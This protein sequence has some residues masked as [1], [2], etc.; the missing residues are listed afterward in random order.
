M[1]GPGGIDERRRPPLRL[2]PTREL[3]PEQ[4]PQSPPPLPP[5][6][7]VVEAERVRAD[8]ATQ[9]DARV[10][11]LGAENETRA[12]LGGSGVEPNGPRAV[13]G[14]SRAD[15]PPADLEARVD[16]LEAEGRRGAFA[17]SPEAAADYARRFREVSPHLDDDTR[18]HLQRPMDEF[19]ASAARTQDP[20][21]TAVARELAPALGS[22][23]VEAFSHALLSGPD[24]RAREASVAVL[25]RAARD[26]ADPL[27][28]RQAGNALLN[29]GPTLDAALR[30]EHPSVSRDRLVELAGSQ[31]ERVNQLLDRARDLDPSVEQDLL[32]RGLAR[33]QLPEV[34]GVLGG[35]IDGVE[36]LAAPLVHPQQTVEGLGRLAGAL[37]SDPLGTGRAI[38]DH[39]VESL[40][41][42][43]ARALTGALVGSVGGGTGHARRLA[44]AGRVVSHVD[45]VARHADDV[46]RRA[47]PVAAP[48]AARTAATGLGDLRPQEVQQIQQVVEEAQRRMDRVLQSVGEAPGALPVDLVVVGSAA[49]G[50]RRNADTELPFGKGPGTRSDI[51]YAVPDRAVR[52]HVFTDAGLARQDQRFWNGLPGFDTRTVGGQLH[53]GMPPI[54]QP[55]VWFRAG[56][57]PV[58]LAPGQ[59]NPS[60]P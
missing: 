7:N 13:R 47:D 25:D 58:Y 16:A 55:R 37:L 12:R 31:P 35:V 29:D 11:A 45:D 44:N 48:G 5:P 60:I 24:A 30:G 49:R 34:G 9:R 15:G 54:D 10:L 19:A 18:R 14:L 27:V 2:E 21:A 28:R 36:G 40:R 38:V 33:T 23:G 22:R 42:D 17:T 51:D 26:N 20:G 57:P 39:A 41:D 6:T 53:E 46:G 50:A 3:S 4:A 43:P 32:G 56:Q 8:D 59:P 52:E 1:S